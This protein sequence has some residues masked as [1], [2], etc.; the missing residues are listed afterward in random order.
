MAPKRTVAKK[1]NDSKA[2][3]GGS[4]SNQQPSGDRVIAVT[5]AEG[6]TG[7]AVLELLASDRF[8]GSYSK[9]VG[10]TFGEPKEDVK[11]ILQEAGVETM[12]VDEID[13]KMIKELG[14]DTLCLI[15]PANKVRQL[16]RL[17]CYGLGL[18]AKQTL[19]LW[20]DRRV[21]AQEKMSLVKQILTLGKKAK[22]VQNVVLVS[23]AGAD[24]AERDKQPRLREF[25][26][27]EVRRSVRPGVRSFSDYEARL[28]WLL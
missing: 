25:I 21:A 10:L 6:Y 17:C 18:A 20:G 26:D 1:E 3:D 13:E 5:A 19:T 23:S 11:E 28:C 24:Y 27:L 14:V 15:P 4:N 16:A 9:L 7:S 2:S 8:K 22:S 12:M